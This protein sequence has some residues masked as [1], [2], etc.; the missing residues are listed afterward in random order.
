MVILLLSVAAENYAYFQTKRQ[1]VSPLIP[2]STILSISEPFIFF[3]LC[4]SLLS[5]VALVFYFYSKYRITIGICLAALL[6]QQFY[7]Y[8]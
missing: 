4:S 2:Q 6:F 8:G 3:S 1:L 5:I 7:V